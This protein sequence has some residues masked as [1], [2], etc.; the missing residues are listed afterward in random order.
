MNEKII[1][2]QVALLESTIKALKVVSG[3]RGTGAALTLAVE[4]YLRRNNDN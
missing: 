1:H 2:C 3:E 4:E